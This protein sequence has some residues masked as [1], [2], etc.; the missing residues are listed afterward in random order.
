MFNKKL[1]ITANPNITNTF[2]APEKRFVLKSML[3]NKFFAYIAK[4][5]SAE[6]LEVTLFKTVFTA[7][8][9]APGF[10]KICTTTDVE[11][12]LGPTD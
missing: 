12:C 7:K 4:V 6:K 9:V 1:S 8:L 3:A 5:A 11:F 2:I 10:V